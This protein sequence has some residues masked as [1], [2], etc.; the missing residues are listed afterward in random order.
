MR[1][2]VRRIQDYVEQVLAPQA[3]PEEGR[4]WTARFMRADQRHADIIQRIAHWGRTCE[5]PWIGPW[6]TEGEVHAGEYMR[7]CFRLT[8]RLLKDT[9]WA[10]PRPQQH[11]AA[12]FLLEYAPMLAA[13]QNRTRDIFPIDDHSCLVCELIN[14]DTFLP[15]VLRI[16]RRV[17]AKGEQT[18]PDHLCT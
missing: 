3:T 8:Q 1:G 2:R 6:R 15:L 5:M 14:D 9:P 10:P 18:A 16:A 13:Y 17:I 7:A 4:R 11:R 12:P